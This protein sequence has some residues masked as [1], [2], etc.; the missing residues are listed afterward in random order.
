MARKLYGLFAQTNL[1]DL[2][3]SGRTWTI[4]AA[5]R[6]NLTGYIDGA[7][8]ITSQARDELLAAGLASA[9]LLEQAEE[10]YQT[11]L[12]HPETFII[13]AFVRAVATKR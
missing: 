13:A 7:R 6:D 9:D 11:L 10:E 4:T 12:E 1:T 8:E 5:Q 3:V 2:E